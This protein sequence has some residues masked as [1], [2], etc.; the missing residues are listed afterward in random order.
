MNRC[1]IQHIVDSSY[2]FPVAPNEIVLRLRTAKNDISRAQVIYESKYVIGQT[3]K[4]ADMRK[5]YTGELF[6]FY[7]VRLSL[8]D[9]RLAYVFYINDG[10]KNFYFSED[11]V[12]ENYD[13]ALGF[14]NFFQYPYINQADIMECVPWMKQAVFYQIFV[15][16]FRMGNKEKDTSYINCRWGDIPT[17]KT[18][19]GGDIRGITEKLDYIKELG[20]NAVY[21]TPIFTSVSNHKYDIS[22]YYR[23]DPQFGTNE[24]LK[25]LVDAAHTR[26]MHVVLDA[27]F[28]HCSENLAQFQ[29]VL[30]K[31]KESPYFD[32]FV[33]R[34]D[35]INQQRDNYETF[36]ACDY[37]PKL[38][39]SNEEVQ[40]FLMDIGTHYLTEYDID[41]WRLDV[42]DEI[43]H[44]FW[45]KFRERMKKVKR[46]AVIIGENWHDAANYL[47]GDQYDSIMN[48]AFTKLCLDYFAWGSKN[49]EQA[50]WKLNELLM[51][52]IDPVNTMML[53]LLDSHDTHR[54]FKETGRNRW[55]VKA[56]L[57]LLFLFPGV[58]CIFYGTE[59]L[60]EGGYD[61]DCRRCMDWEKANPK[62]EYSDIYR[63]IESLSRLRRE[64]NTAEGRIGIYAESD[65]LVLK[66]ETDERKIKLFVNN[67]A[68]NQTVDSCDVSPYSF[69][70][71]LNGGTVL[72]EQM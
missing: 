58:P 46:D 50:A 45:R 31:G 9:T 10:E 20:C 40:E 1:A 21:L 5:A 36:A 68:G 52:N 38:N 18:F 13:F 54:F 27:V 51:R 72:Y 43:S 60:T 11:G 29:D 47:R 42:S 62:G 56:A 41:G 53:N 12:T 61:P 26:G 33:I 39:T 14:Y 25:E 34:G 6:D 64:Q 67:T 70:I 17:P 55:K 65:V 28:N 49:A 23:V 32:W 37:M 69:R 7:E 24:D 19:A 2:C 22:D 8:E 71:T 16:R 44:Y 3:Q 30:K 63:L 66:N 59:I 35:R 48:Y 15:D 57:A 4:T